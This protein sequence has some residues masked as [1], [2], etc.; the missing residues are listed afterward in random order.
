MSYGGVTKLSIW[1]SNSVLTYSHYLILT[2]R[3]WWRNGM[4]TL[5]TLLACGENSAIASGYPS[6]LRVFF[7]VSIHQP[8]WTQRWGLLYGWSHLVQLYFRHSLLC[9]SWHWRAIPNKQNLASHM[10][11]SLFS[12]V[13]I[14]ACLVIIWRTAMKFT[15]IPRICKTLI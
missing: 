12:L 5:C 4:E 9:C 7:V 10:G 6:Y 3:P 1:L 14:Y 11:H 13:L 8:R 2:T 15:K